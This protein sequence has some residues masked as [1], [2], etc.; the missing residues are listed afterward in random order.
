MTKQRLGHIS[1]QGSG[2]SP[3]GSTKQLG[4]AMSVHTS[5]HASAQEHSQ[6]SDATAEGS[7]VVLDV[8]EWL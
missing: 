8:A 6:D 2:S 3:V 1:K 4:M 7:L 5:G